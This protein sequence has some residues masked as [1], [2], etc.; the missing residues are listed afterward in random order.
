MLY[1]DYTFDLA[2]DHIILDDEINIDKLGWKAGDYFR[3]TNV[4]GKIKLEK[5]DPLVKFLKDG[6]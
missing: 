5:V 6:E 1:F 2:P 4:N 3:V